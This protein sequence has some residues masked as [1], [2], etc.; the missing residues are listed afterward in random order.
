MVRTGC[1]RP[2]V[3]GVR[4]GTVV[5]DITVV[6]CVGEFVVGGVAAVGAEFPRA[7]VVA[8][9]LVAVS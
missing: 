9:V 6:P 1:D 3:V 8:D 4:T 7:V 2:R 5:L